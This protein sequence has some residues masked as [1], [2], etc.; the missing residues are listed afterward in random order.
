M[1]LIDA[2]ALDNELGISDEDINF[3]FLLQEAPTVDPVKHEQW[4]L[5]DE[6]LPDKKGY[7]LTSD[8][9]GVTITQWDGRGWVRTSVVII[10]EYGRSVHH[11]L[12][13]IAWMPLPKPYG[14]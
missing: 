8:R 14:R 4:V 5:C 1:R 13:I 9:F 11:G 12:P 7:Y 6:Q 10:T 3:H 2:D